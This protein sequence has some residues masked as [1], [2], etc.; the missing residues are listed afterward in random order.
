MQPIKIKLIII[1]KNI[2]ANILSYAYEFFARIIYTPSPLVPPS[3]S[4]I[5]APTN[6]YETEI[7]IP[8][9]NPV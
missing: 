9:I 8:D 1:I 2:T 6:E 5:T 7:L 3:H 4:A